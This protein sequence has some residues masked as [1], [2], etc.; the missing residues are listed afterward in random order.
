MKRKIDTSDIPELTYAQLKRARR[1]TLQETKAFKRA[2]RE[3][4]KAK[5]GN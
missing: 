4:R 5:G 1:V 2:V 3:H